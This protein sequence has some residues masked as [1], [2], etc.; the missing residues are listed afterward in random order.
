MG[1][2][3][4]TEAELAAKLGVV[5]PHLDERQRAPYSLRGRGEPPAQEVGERPGDQ[6]RIDPRTTRGVSAIIQRSRAE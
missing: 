3:V 5:L 4:V 2:F 1:D 6:D